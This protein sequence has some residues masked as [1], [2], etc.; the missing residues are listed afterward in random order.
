MFRLKYEP[1]LPYLVNTR[2]LPLVLQET[3][4]L[5][6]VCLVNRPLYPVIATPQRYTSAMATLPESAVDMARIKEESTSGV[7][8]KESSMIALYG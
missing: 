4:H 7:R 2:I 1:S 8:G 3:T 6:L 5:S